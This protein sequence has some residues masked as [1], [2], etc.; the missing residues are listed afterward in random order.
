M[1][2]AIVK[3]LCVV[4]V[5]VC[6][7]CFAWQGSNAAPHV[8]NWDWKE[9]PKISTP[10]SCL[11]Y[12][13]NGWTYSI[14]VLA[15]PDD[16]T[17]AGGIEVGNGRFTDN[18]QNIQLTINE[19][20]SDMYYVVKIPWYSGSST[21]A[22]TTYIYCQETH[23]DSF[24]ATISKVDISEYCESYF[25][26]YLTA[27]PT[28]G[29][30][31]YKY[32]WS[33]TNGGLYEGQG[34]DHIQVLHVNQNG[35]PQCYADVTKS[36]TVTITI[37][38]NVWKMSD[39]SAATATAS[40]TL[41]AIRFS[42][43]SFKPG[44]IGYFDRSNGWFGNT[45][46]TVATI[47]TQRNGGYGTYTY[48]WSKSTSP[49]GGYSNISNSNTQNL[50]I[51][52][53]SNTT[54][55]KQYVTNSSCPSET[56]HDGYTNNG[57]F[58]CVI[59]IVATASPSSTSTYYGGSV[60][61]S[62]SSTGG[63]ASGK[64]YKWYSSST[65]GGTYSE[66]QN[67]VGTSYSPTG[68]TAAKYYKCKVFDAEHSG[69][70]E[71]NVVA[72]SVR[73]Q[74]VAGTIS[75][76]GVTTYSGG[77]VRLTASAATGGNGSYG[78]QWQVYNGS[79]WSDMSGKT[80]LTCD[81]SES[82]TGTTNLS[83][84]YRLKVTGD[85]Q[86]KYTGEVTV[87]W[88]PQLVAGTISGGVTTYSGNSVSLSVGAAS[89][90][91]S[92]SY[93]YQWQES[94][95]GG[96]SWTNVGTNSRSYST[97]GSGVTK[98]YRVIVTDADNQKATASA[99][100]VTWRS[101]LAIG[102]ITGGNVIVGSNTSV[103]LQVGA[104]T[105]GTG[106][107][108]Y[109][110]Q[111][112]RSTNNGNTWGS[113]AGAT[114]LELED[115]G[116]DQTKHYKVVVTDGDNQTATSA[117]VSV[118]WNLPFNL[119]SIAGGGVTTYSGGSV[120]LSVSPAGGVGSYTY[121]WKE[122]VDGS[123][124]SN[125]AGD[126]KCYV[127]GSGQMK[128][129]KVAVTC[130]GQTMESDYVTVE[131]RPALAVGE[132]AGGGQSTRSGGTITL[133]VNPTGG[134]GTY[135]YQWEVFSGSAWS[136]ILVNG[137]GNSYSE[138]N[139]NLSG[140]NLTKKYRVKVSSDNQEFYAVP[141][142]VSWHTVLV[143]GAITGGNIST[144]GCDNV[145]LTAHP[146]G[147]G[148]EGTYSFQ[149][150]QSTDGGSTWSSIAGA[151]DRTCIVTGSDQTALYKV[152]VTGDG[153]TV[154]SASVSVTWRQALVAG[155]VTGGG[156]TTYSG[157]SVELSVSP[158]GGNGSFT[159]QWQVVKGSSWVDVPGAK[160]QSFTA[161]STNAG[162]GNLVKYYRVVVSSDG[163][164]EA[165]QP[166]TVT[167]RPA[168]AA[169]VRGA[170]TTHSGGTVKLTA[171]TSGGNGSCSYQWETSSDNVSWSDIPNATD[172]T[173]QVSGSNQ[174][175]YFRVKVSGDNQIAHSE[176]VSVGWRPALVA[177]SITGSGQTTYSG[178]N[179][180]LTANP[181]GGN[182]N[183]TYQWQV[184]DNNTDWL[185]IKDAKER[186]LAE[187]G[188][189]E[190]DVPIVIYYRV[191]VSGDNQTSVSE[192]AN[193][194]HRPSLKIGKIQPV[195]SSVVYGG[196]NVNLTVAASGGDG[197]YSYQWYRKNAETDWTPVGGNSASFTD[198]HENNTNAAVSYLYKVV[199]SGDHQE[200]ESDALQCSWTANMQ[201]EALIYA[202]E[203]VSYGV[204]TPIE[205]RVIN[206]SGI[207]DYQW[208]TLANGE[209]QN[210]PEN[211]N[212]ILSIALTEAGDYRC[213][214]T[215][216]LYPTRSVTTGVASLDVWPDLVPGSVTETSHTVDNDS[217]SISGTTP[218]GGN[219]TYHYRWEKRSGNG[220][221]VPM[222]D[223]T[224]A[225]T[226][227]PESNTTYRRY[228]S[229]GDQEKPAF[230][231]QVNVPLKSGAIAA[232]RTNDFYYA[233]QRLPLLKDD[234][235]AT[236]GNTDGS[237]NYQWYWKREGSDAFEPIQGATAA[238]YQPV[239]LS[240]S[241]SFYRA[242]I[243]GDDVL[244]TNVINLTIKQPVVSLANLKE[245]YCKSDTVRIQASGIEGGQY[246]WFD[247]SGK[248]LAAGPE[249]YLMTITESTTV[250]LRS[251]S[252]SGDLLTKENVVLNVIDMTP[253]F[254]TDK[255]I[256]RAGESIHFTNN[257]ANYVR[258]E[259]NFGDGADGSFEEEPWHYYN[260]DGVFSV[261]LRLVSREGC[262]VETIMTNHITVSSAFTD[263]TA[264]SE[265]TVSVY[266]NP[267]V[268]FLMVES[269]GESH[270]TIVGSTGAVVFDAEVSSAA[271]I[272]ISA[273]P[274]GTYTV[275]V[276]D[277]NG[278]V[279]YEKIVKY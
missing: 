11:D 48:T 255:I 112:Y 234:V 153:Q 205:V 30:G 133:S 232:S 77:S 179:V 220:E 106:S 15:C 33:S 140:S 152:K 5:C 109:S 102:T 258:C 149:W 60:T 196:D 169:V 267:A 166:V 172:A 222:P 202:Q 216:S 35:A 164:N 240:V 176:A 13:R 272:D 107:D 174:T 192:V 241:T 230:E 132:I 89:G 29:S 252:G 167:Y 78:Y 21:V 151:I 91:N 121:Q 162:A 66:I 263:V 226:V 123:V 70:I 130:D 12:L 262:V 203:K 175:E 221:Y 194:T 96:G 198:S 23:E 74:L 94:S 159:Y 244:N 264:D 207:Y 213:V 191:V 85:S 100:S 197:V 93:S 265:K 214:V 217:I 52:R 235:S 101:P 51:E 251:Y 24:Y 90:G 57:Y 43:N 126:D 84:K 238:D 20:Y 227:L 108:T 31:N 95:N 248:Q 44:N 54:F 26:A 75:G 239:G 119:G 3:A 224:P 184:S 8:W 210:I 233:G 118:T 120:Q 65:S 200:A 199:V 146:S 259:W 27:S 171:S 254:L 136:K 156:Q 188:D 189:N 147:G 243:D 131:W 99:V 212:P 181:S 117:V 182:N 177:G 266:P 46:T 273:F 9:N 225:I 64:T 49:D 279:H 4:L 114:G 22:V 7:N 261:R 1:K 155:T 92:S 135:T 53:P 253:D 62:C 113:V 18:N 69:G 45:A 183:Y 228:D 271:K 98:N 158:L 83:K 145:E 105:G 268:D 277:G 160:N 173:C 38:D 180:T 201:I 185:N 40:V 124:W 63:R 41:N 128:Y 61:L 211:D 249:L 190:T 79:Q 82:N 28:G 87:T 39:G 86:T 150:Y 187:T 104:A 59:P 129:Y 103:T 25:Q 17:E 148:G 270:V 223:T 139:T 163:Q 32:S 141:V 275:I 209:W 256:A 71:S 42:P 195:G 276:V 19:Y 137:N 144:Y 250:Q 127:S 193:V 178:G 242:V 138:A 111:W 165:T 170:T 37:T 168:L 125:I 247:A 206:G 14:T 36:K 6:N 236:G 97:S 68:L 186:E 245:L 269:E 229:S 143:A 219:G 122:S 161:S 10:S 67:A 2:K 142:T 274:E 134:N 73:S 80:S 88:R 157:G 58:T 154:E 257:S 204:T 76:G 278:G 50:N 215:D 55:Y 72:V 260:N 231:F 116:Y 218:A 237:P 246:R 110:Y 81:V 208:Q 34:T 47:S 16:E 56:Y 115:S